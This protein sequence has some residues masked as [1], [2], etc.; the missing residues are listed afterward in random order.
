MTPGMAMATVA[1]TL[2]CVTAQ[3]HHA[4]N[5]DWL[6]AR[7]ERQ[8]QHLNRRVLAELFVHV[9][10]EAFWEWDLSDLR[11]TPIP[12]QPQRLAVSRATPS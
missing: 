11:G 9:Q 5:N 4:V 10:P 6:E 1:A 12:R 2:S 3:E 7:Y 8:C